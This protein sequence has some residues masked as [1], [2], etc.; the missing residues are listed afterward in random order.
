MHRNALYYVS[1]SA[2]LC[3]VYCTSL[4][5]YSA[6]QCMSLMVYRNTQMHMVCALR[7]PLLTKKHAGSIFACVVLDSPIQRI[8]M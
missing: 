3:K 5:T 2:L 4:H 1:C 6:L 7:C 8:K